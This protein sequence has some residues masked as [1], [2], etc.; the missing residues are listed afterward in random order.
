MIVGLIGAGNMAGA[1]ARGWAAASTGPDRIVCTDV[2]Q[3]RARA[4]AEEVA[5]RAVDSNRALAEEADVLVLAMKPGALAPV[6]EDI[7]VPVTERRLPVVS[8]LG[9]TGIAAIQDALGPETVSYTHLTLPT[10]CSV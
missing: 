10:I 8:I 2:D 5:G 9:A 6:A 4:L 1:L 7:R 3:E